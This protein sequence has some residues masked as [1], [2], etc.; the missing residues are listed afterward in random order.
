MTTGAGISVIQ[1]LARTLIGM[2]DQPDMLYPRLLY[3]LR[4][5]RPNQM[6]GL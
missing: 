2:T 5:T 6:G 3:P 4:R 1:P